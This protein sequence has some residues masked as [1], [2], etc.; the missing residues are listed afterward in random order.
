MGHLRTLLDR[1]LPAVMLAMLFGALAPKGFMPQFGPDG[2][3]IE[4][5]SGLGNKSTTIA[6]DDPRYRDYLQLAAARGDSVDHD[7]GNDGDN[8][9]PSCAFAGLATLAMPADP[10]TVPQPVRADQQSF[11]IKHR[12][13]QLYTYSG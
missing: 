8:P 9:M 6:R 12:Q 11:E 5:C 1:I 13:P 10:V 7:S 2:L 4:L 3:T